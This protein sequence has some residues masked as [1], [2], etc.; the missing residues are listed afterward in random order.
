VA[1]ANVFRIGELS[2]RSGVSPE[3]LRAWERR[4][5]LL[6]PVRSKG[7]LRLYSA[8]DLERVRTMQRHLDAGM[9]AAEA[10]RATQGE[11]ALPDGPRIDLEG[12][13]RELANALDEFD[14]PRAQTIFDDLIAASTVERVLSDI[15]LPFLEELGNRWERGEASVAQEHFSSNVLRGRMLG[16]A[17]GWGRGV[18]P[19]AVLAC[20]PGEQHDLGALAFGL[21]LRSRGWRI[22]YFGSDTPIATVAQ[23]AAQLD[24]SLVVLSGV[25][26]GSIGPVA[27]EI[28][29]LARRWPVA[30]GGKAALADDLSG[31]DVLLLPGDAVAEAEHVSRLR[32]VNRDDV[33]SGSA[34]RRTR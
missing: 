15:V 9:A 4:Y 29:E 22:A 19:V 30:I 32:L 12:A 2:R 25:S 24:P 17:R 16:L 14:E 11:P 28:E 7:G 27:S 20:L 21:A 10:A 31:L 18:G 33:P 1:E 23:A 3:L 26:V 13:R 8:D 34:T 6:E 5:G